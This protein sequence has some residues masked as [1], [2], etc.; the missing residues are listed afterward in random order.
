MTM[1]NTTNASRGSGS[2]H[3]LVRRFGEAVSP[4]SKEGVTDLISRKLIALQREVERLE[5]LENEMP[6]GM[7]KEFYALIYS[8]LLGAK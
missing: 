3:R 6:A 8:A 4:T 5:K 7:S 1:K 2:L